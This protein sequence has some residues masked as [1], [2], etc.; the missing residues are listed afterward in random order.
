MTDES[1]RGGRVPNRREFVGLGVGAFV[2]AA[3]PAV[4]RRDRGLIR[5]RIPVMG[6]VAEVAVVHR[7]G[8]YAQ[9]AASAALAELRRV[10]RT[11]TRFDPTSEVGRA[12]RAAL[13]RPVGVSGCTAD[14]VEAALRWAELSDGVFDPALAGAAALWS[15]DRRSEPPPAAEVRRWA[16]RRL[17]RSVEV[18]RG[19]A[20]AALRFHD[21]D[22]ALDLGGIAK[23]H[24]V[25]RAAAV[26]REWGIVDGLVNAG[27]D[28]Y[29]L[30]T[31]EDG[32]PWEVG[33]RDPADPRRLSTTLRIRDGAVATS[34][35]Y[36]AFFEH[37]GR[38][39]HHLLDPATGE[40]RRTR[41]RSLTVAAPDCMTADAAATALFGDPRAEAER[42]LAEAAPGASIRH[43]A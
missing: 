16:D 25:D 38:R 40:P 42:T 2:V 6:T 10:D 13:R 22:A 37:G 19:P 39:Y 5:R 31:S 26:L 24:G 43:S 17:W 12:N 33:V 23:G 15:P 36:E 32:D 20:G 8:R 4:L 29:A 1:R 28:L 30:G 11:M 18:D 14:V 27:G 21:P 35:D 9:A 7:D 41:V 34:G 3:L